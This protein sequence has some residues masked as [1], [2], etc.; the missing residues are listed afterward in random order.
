MTNNKKTAGRPKGARQMRRAD[1][2]QIA[3]LLAKGLS[4]AQI[5][6]VIGRGRATVYNHVK[7][8]KAQPVLPLGGDQ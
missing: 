7:A 6:L 4:P 8:M 3:D 1:Q 5:A 2:M